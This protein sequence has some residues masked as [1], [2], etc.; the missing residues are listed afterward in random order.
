MENKKTSI[1]E[2]DKY[3]KE[4]KAEEM[5]WY[6][7]KLD[8]DLVSQLQEL[9]INSGKFIDI[10]TG[11]A[12]QAAKLS[13]LGFKVYATDLSQTAVERAKK[14]YPEVDFKTDNIL[15]TEINQTFD[16]A[17][18]RGCF[19]VIP[20]NKRPQYVENISKILNKNSLLFLKCFSIEQ[21][22]NEGPN[23]ISEEDI[24]K[25]FS[26][27]FEILKIINSTFEGNR[28]PSPKAIFTVLKKK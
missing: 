18:D 27:N 15:D 28:K 14:L 26:E 4:N 22:G 17:F 20:P 1:T 13:E 10:G 11:P 6:S 9:K 12:T 25:C 8:H 5:S 21:P 24:N 7:E 19:H 3:Y 16:F 23:R 2:W